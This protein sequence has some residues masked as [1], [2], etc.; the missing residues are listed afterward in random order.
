MQSKG[1]WNCA[2]RLY[3]QQVIVRFVLICIVHCGSMD[4]DILVLALW[5]TLGSTRSLTKHFNRVHC[6]N[7]NFGKN[8][9]R[10]ILLVPSSSFLVTEALPNILWQHQ[11]EWWWYDGET[12]VTA[13]TLLFASAKQTSAICCCPFHHNCT[14]LMCVSVCAS[15]WWSIPDGLIYPHWNTFLL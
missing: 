10:E 8:L 11:R 13:L 15:V 4:L 12:V 7:T 9:K 14:F 6:V 1:D 2:H 3:T 5:E